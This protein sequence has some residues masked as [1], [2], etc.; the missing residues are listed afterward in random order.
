M[1]PLV[2]FGTG[3]L[4]QLARVLFSEGGHHQPVAFTVERVYLED[5]TFQGLPVPL[6]TT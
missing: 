5:S 1:K 2:I 6:E 3:Y 4:A